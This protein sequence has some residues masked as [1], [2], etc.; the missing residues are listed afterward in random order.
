MAGWFEGG[1]AAAERSLRSAFASVL[2][3]ADGQAV[4]A[5]V[6]L[7]GRY[8]LTCAHVVNAALGRD[9]FV[10]HPP[11]A[12]E[13]LQVLFREGG[14]HHRPPALLRAAVEEWIAPRRPDGTAPLAK[15]VAWHGD[16]AV[17]RLADEPP[18]FLEPQR[19]HDMA[20]GQSLRAWYGGGQAVSVVDVRVKVCDADRAYLDASA[21]GPGIVAGYSG[22][23]LWCPDAQAV[24]GLAVG[25]LHSGQTRSGYDDRAFA[26][27]WQ[28]IRNELRNTLGTDRARQ[29]LPGQRTGQRRRLPGLSPMA[30]LLRSV[31]PGAREREDAAR[32]L[33]DHFRRYADDPFDGEPGPGHRAGRTPDGTGPAGTA[34]DVRQLATL[35][36]EEPRSL[37]VLAE[38]LRPHDKD[39]AHRLFD[40]GRSLGAP[41]LLTPDQHDWLL[42][43]LDTVFLDLGARLPP[44]DEVARAALPMLRLPVWLRTDGYARRGF[45]TRH[46][47]LVEHLE[48]YA[49]APSFAPSVRRVPVLLKYLEYLAAA[50]AAGEQPDEVLGEAVRLRAWSE[51]V[52][53]QLGVSKAGLFEHRLAAEE[54]ALGRVS[55]GPPARLVVRLIRHERGMRGG[56]GSFRSLMWTDVGGTGLRQVGGHGNRPCTAEEVARRVREEV[57]GW[58]DDEHDTLPTVEFFLDADDIDLPI[59]EWDTSLAEERARTDPA[60]PLGLEY[61]LV[62]RLAAELGTVPAK[63]R[64]K[65][66]RRRHR[67]EPVL[68][69]H[70]GHGRQQLFSVL[71]QDGDAACVV[72]SCADPARLRQLAARC[73]EFGVPVVMWDRSAR[74][75]PAA[76]PFTELLGPL[77]EIAGLVWR[78]RIGSY[79]RAED[80]PL[81]P[82]LAQEDL[83]RPAPPILR[84]ADPDEDG[85]D[86]APADACGG[87]RH[88]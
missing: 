17:L 58:G 30:D 67:P 45:A 78:Y 14:S 48:G 21:T 50:A 26:L 51:E 10:Q 31:L 59:E 68:E 40:T 80:F 77:A 44:I 7:H 37:A 79:G 20:V 12:H 82:V 47:A 5:G 35:L 65:E 87:G 73:L 18:A 25:K 1:G 88:D 64:A 53:D 71:K 57:A 76:E 11:P 60:R 8:V 62:V 86:T 19:W 9:L 27:S 75:G 13:A 84:L 36:L 33:A 29:L 42:D 81:R 69:L 49:G 4:G 39:A 6:L 52:A 56:A 66:L 24:V 34:P 46:A 38:Y 43:I 61:P 70:D 54:W 16:L 63:E 23:P 3:R 32:H 85:N 22:G 41:G 74:G 83:A 28:A 55:A 72:L 2:G 15:D